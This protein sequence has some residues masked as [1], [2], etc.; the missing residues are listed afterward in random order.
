MKLTIFEANVYDIPGKQKIPI[1]PSGDKEFIFKTF[2]N[3]KPREMYQLM[4]SNF[5][6]NIPLN[7]TTP[8]KS[9]RQIKALKKYMTEEI[10]Y[11]ILDIDDVSS[12]E[13]MNKILDYFRKYK[14]IIGESKSHNAIR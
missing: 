11:I 14:C 3:L 9:R 13:D 5:I 2:H 8:I 1:S 10:N 4:V 7:L 12:A 6:L